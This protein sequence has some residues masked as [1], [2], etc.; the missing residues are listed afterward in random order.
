MKWA[1]LIGTW[2]YHHLIFDWVI[3][4]PVAKVAKDPPTPILFMAIFDRNEWQKNFLK[5]FLTLVSPFQS[6][7]DFKDRL[8]I[9]YINLNDHISVNFSDIL[10]NFVP[11]I[12]QIL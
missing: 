11:H 4:F 1:I 5:L 9:N 6:F 7:P 3:F 10:S 8:E 12:M 2:Q